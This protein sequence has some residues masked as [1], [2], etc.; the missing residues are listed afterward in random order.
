MPARSPLG[1]IIGMS[2]VVALLAVAPGLSFAQS[3]DVI[4]VSVSAETRQLLETA[5]GHIGSGNADQAYRMLAADELELAGNAYFDYLLGISALDTGR[6]SEAI[7]ALRRSV[8]VEPRFSGARMELA[9]AYYESGNAGQA[10]PLF[11]ALLDESPPPGVRDIIQQYIGAIDQ[12]P[13]TP[14]SSFDGYLET[15]VGL[16]TNANGSTSNRQFMGFFLSSNNVEIESPFAEIGAGFRWISPASNQFAWLASARVGHRTNPDATFVDTTIV[17]GYGGMSWQRG[18]F[19]GRVGIDG[20]FS[21]RHGSS[22]GGF[23]SP[24][25]NVAGSDEAYG[26]VDFLAGRNYGDWDVSFGLRYGADRFDDSLEVLDVDRLLYTLD[27]GRRLSPTT[28][29]SI[30]AIGG[31]DNEAQSGSPYG[32][33]KIGARIALSTGMNERSFLHA[34][35]GTL[36]SDYDGLFFGLPREDTQTSAII[37]LEFRDVL[38]DG[39]SFTPMFR[40]IDNE[41]DVSLYEYDRLEV[42]LQI[43]WMPR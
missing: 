6:H 27:L 18:P 8:S 19:F 16:D 4:D 33:S 38:T 29:L 31:Q 22:G 36:V 17:S 25:P 34:S 24:I 9:R 1:R 2:F 23:G 20:Y 41:S 43:R 28:R 26:G 10:R 11:V 42:G 15:I 12:R 21:A 13:P 39:L 32:N 3:T 35:L 14:R 40:Y 30:Q 5:E 7:F 37:R